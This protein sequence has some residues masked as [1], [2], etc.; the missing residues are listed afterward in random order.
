MFLSIIEFYLTFYVPFYYMV[1]H[2]I[3]YS[4]T[5]CRNP[6]FWLQHYDNKVQ[7]KLVQCWDF[8]ELSV[9]NS[10]WVGSCCRVYSVVPRHKV[11]LRRGAGLSH[12]E[13]RHCRRDVME[14][15]N[16]TNGSIRLAV[17]RLVWTTRMVSCQ[18]DMILNAVIF[19]VRAV[20]FSS[21]FFSLLAC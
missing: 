9:M 3:V 11:S 5:Y 12:V 20:L 4:C 14:E 7:F 13:S 10:S 2:C 16:R 19:S 6:A 21:E 15:V 17:A 8:V 18:M 1:L